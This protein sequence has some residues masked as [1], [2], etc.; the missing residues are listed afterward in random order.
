[1]WAAK[2]IVHMASTDGIRK[3]MDM[4]HVVCYIFWGVLGKHHNKKLIMAC[5]SDV[6]ELE[7]GLADHAQKSE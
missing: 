7:R 6:Y 4:V 1:M 5:F 2:F 3:F